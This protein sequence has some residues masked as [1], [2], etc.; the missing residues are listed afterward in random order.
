MHYDV[1]IIGGSFAG[2]SAAMQLARARRQVLLVDAARPRNRY[3]AHAHGFLG[4]DGV[5]PQEIVANARAQ[6]ARYPTVSF[7]DGEAIQALAQDGGFAVVMA[8]GEQVRGARLILATGMRDELPPLPGL[9]ARWGQTVLHCPY[10]HGFEVAGEPLGVLA[11]HP[12]SVHQAML[13]PDWGPT[14]Y[15]T[16]GQ[17]EPSPEDARHLAARG[18]LVER[19]PV[20][21]LL[22]DAPA[23]TGV[24]LA[25]GREV[26]LRALFVASRVHMASPLAGQLGCAF[27]EGPLGPVIRVDDMK[28]T[29]VPGVFAA[30]DASTPMSNAT[31]ASASGVM[32]GVCAHRSL[33]MS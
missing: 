25:D 11:A 6:L 2:L 12:M 8:G 1:I 26:P 29:T 22:G 30:G 31:L 15:F 28:Q 4:Q 32:A 18:V 13:L 17:F 33:V 27:D 21:A 9:Q 3:A 7:L 19:T 24:V 14:T 16:Q 5:P 23:L 20:V 10:C